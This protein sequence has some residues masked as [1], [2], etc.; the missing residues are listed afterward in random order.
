MAMVKKNLMKKFDW[1]L[2]VFVCLFSTAMIVCLFQNA[3]YFTEF[4][5]ETSDVDFG[6]VPPN[7]KT[8]KSVRF[9]NEGNTTL[10]IN[11][12]IVG[13]GCTEVNVSKYRL[14]PGEKGDINIVLTGKN[15][16]GNSHADIHFFSNDSRFPIKKITVYYDSVSDFFFNPKQLDFGLIQKNDLPVKKNIKIIETHSDALTNRENLSVSLDTDFLSACIVQEKTL[17]RYVE[18]NVSDH[19][20]LGN[21]F[22]SLYV[23][24]HI[25]Q[26]KYFADVIGCVRGNVYSNPPVID[27][28]GVIIEEEH[29]NSDEHEERVAVLSRKQ[30]TLI[31]IQKIVV[32]ESLCNIVHFRYD[33]K[34]SKSIIFYLSQQSF[35][36]EFANKEMRGR[37]LVLCSDVEGENF[38]LNI[39]LRFA[40]KK[41]G[42]KN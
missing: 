5:L 25:E 33:P 13:C 14:R 36:S 37:V 22:E 7:T 12:V 11:K 8:S 28:G 30:D 40:A 39:P 18:V 4:N 17:G 32:C 23:A 21:F 2:I 6:V 38:T 15:M 3:F 9:S 31:T 27:F 42:V 20:P 34:D 10:V 24:D 16:P 35:S 41:R 29:F 19:A 1:I 26:K